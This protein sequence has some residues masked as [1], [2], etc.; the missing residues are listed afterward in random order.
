MKLAGTPN[1]NQALHGIGKLSP[2]PR[3]SAALR[4]LQFT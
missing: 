3:A 4:E 2:R 1:V